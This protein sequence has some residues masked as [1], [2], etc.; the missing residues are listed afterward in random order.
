[1]VV[2]LWRSCVSF[3]IFL[4]KSITFTFECV[5]AE[6]LGGFEAQWSFGDHA[7]P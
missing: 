5:V 6:G 2:K 4:W 7:F 1:M 3:I